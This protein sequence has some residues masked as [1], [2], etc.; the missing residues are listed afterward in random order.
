MCPGRPV[1]AD[2]MI[3]IAKEKRKQR[4]IE[5]KQQKVHAENE[6]I[7]KMEGNGEE[8]TDTIESQAAGIWK[9]VQP[10]S[11][12]EEK[13]DGQEDSTSSQED[14]EEEE[15]LTAEQLGIAKIEENED[16]ADNIKSQAAGIWTIIQPHSM[17]KDDGREDSASSQEEDEEE[18]RV[19][20]EDGTTYV[21]VPEG[22]TDEQLAQWLD[23]QVNYYSSGSDEMAAAAQ[24]TN[25]DPDWRP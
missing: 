19:E 24:D 12:A 2:D 6:S 18:E 21:E 16:T 5:R 8:P 9:I 1:T 17:A 22:L 25:S 15:G 14:E 20:E 10:H 11:Q 4:L 3:E 23:A 7:V 13:E